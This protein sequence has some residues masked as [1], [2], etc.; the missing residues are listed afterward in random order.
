MK[1]KNMQDILPRVEK[2]STYLGTEINSVKKNPEQVKLHMLLA[3]PDVY[4]IGTSHFGIQILYHIL[5]CRD[6]IAAE[7]VF[8]PGRDMEN[9]LRQNGVPLQSLESE[10]VLSD[11]DIIGFSLLYELNYTNIL[12]ILD[13]AGIPFRAKERD[14]SHPLL[15][16]GGPC[17][18]NPEPVADFFDALV[19]GDGETVISEMA[20]TWIKWKEGGT[21]DREI[22]FKKWAGIRGVYIPS[23]FT[24][25]CENSIQTLLPRFPDYFLVKR[26]VVPDLDQAPFPP[27]PVLPFGRPVHD[28]LRLELARGCTRGCRF[29]QAGMIYRPVRERSPQNILH[30]FAS[31]VKASGYEDVSLL[32][33]STGDYGCIREL[34]ARMTEQ[35]TAEHIALSMPSLRAGTLTPE[36]MELIKK[37]RKTGFTIAPEAGSQRLRDVI[38][39]NIC[40][41]DIFDTVRDAFAAGWQVIKLYFMIGLPTEED[42][43][44]EAIARLVR[45]LKKIKG[46]GGRKGRINVS[47]GTFIPKS[48]TPFQW[49]PQISPDESREKI[50]RLRDMLKMPG[51]QYKWQHPEISFME[52]LWAGGDRSFSRLLIRAYE[53]G[54]RLDGW[55]DHFR[56]D[57]WQEALEECGIN[58]DFRLHRERDPA[59]IF[60]WDHIHIGVEKDFLRDEWEKALKG[61]KT[62]DCRQGDC[63]GCGVCDFEHIQPIV[64]GHF[65][66]FPAEKKKMPGEN[67]EVFPV[68]LFFSKTGKARFFGHLE[69]V[70]IFVRAI[71]RAAVPI[72]YSRGFHPMPKISFDDPLPVGMESMEESFFMRLAESVSLQDIP[73]QLN[74]QL[75]AGLRVTGCRI[76][77]ARFAREKKDIVSYRVTSGH[78]EFAES[79]FAYFETSP[80]ILLSKRN[81]KGKVSHIDLK[82]AVIV[83]ERISPR[84]VEIRLRKTEGKTVR[85]AEALEI[86]FALEKDALRTARILKVL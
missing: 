68:Q 26:A 62:Q 17:T 31:A 52:G 33:L 69:M 34:I 67:P 48:H 82:K 11:F 57:L 39:K 65:P 8:T 32:S 20:D 3:F 23:F 76:A 59:E 40:E 38:N 18:C 9:E 19:I 49:C 47:V 56:F 54:C 45:E 53:K 22:L 24:P 28:R 55:S 78:G 1:H 4:E 29:C 16:A 42:A 77:A 75:P 70:S 73:E 44:V 35:C 79:G 84:E 63:R 85:P 7:R 58:T 27:A 66:E 74:A 37:V 72:C 10:T 41:Q 60:P 46:P 83:L 86:I 25:S 21:D 51:V 81:R 61:E 12:T 6:D 64:H 30:L 15:I 43:D 5:N 13:L 80:E 2:P 50:N 71:R 14:N 36:L